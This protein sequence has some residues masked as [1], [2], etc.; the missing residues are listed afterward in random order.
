MIEATSLEFQEPAGQR[1]GSAA[2]T[3]DLKAFNLSIQTRDA[4]NGRW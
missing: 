3:G 1:L 2:T 4:M